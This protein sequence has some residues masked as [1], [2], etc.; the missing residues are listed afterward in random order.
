MKRNGNSLH[1]IIGG[2]WDGKKM[3]LPCSN[4]KG[5]DTMWFAVNGSDHVRMESEGILTSDTSFRKYKHIV[6][7]NGEHAWR[8][9]TLLDW[10]DT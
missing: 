3:H 5:E 1:E 10:K 2:G 4:S 9:M 7:D 8:E 6:K